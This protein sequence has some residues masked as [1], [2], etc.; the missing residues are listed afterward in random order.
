MKACS[1]HQQQKQRAYSHKRSPAVELKI[2]DFKPILNNPKRETTKKKSVIILETTKIPKIASDD[3]TEEEVF[4]AHKHLSSSGSDGM[5][6]SSPVNKQKGGAN[7]SF[8]IDYMSVPQEYTPTK[9]AHQ[10][11]VVEVQQKMSLQ[12]ILKATE[13]MAKS[14]DGKKRRTR[15]V[16]SGETGGSSIYER[17]SRQWSEKRARYKEPY[18]RSMDDLANCT[19]KPQINPPSKTKHLPKSYSE[20]KIKKFNED[21]IKTLLQIPLV[22]TVKRHN[23][24]SFL[25]KQNEFV[26]AKEQTARSLAK[27]L[28][29]FT[30]KPIINQYSPE[31]REVNHRL[32]SKEQQQ[33]ERKRH[34]SQE[35]IGY[36]KQKLAKQTALESVSLNQNTFLD[37]LVDLGF[38]PFHSSKSKI[39]LKI[40]DR[41][42][43]GQPIIARERMQELL[44]DLNLGFVSKLITRKQRQF[45]VQNKLSSGSRLS[46]TKHHRYSNHPSPRKSQS[47]PKQKSI[48]PSI[49]HPLPSSIS[50]IL[51]NTTLNSHRPLMPN[52]PKHVSFLESTTLESVA[53]RPTIGAPQLILD[54]NI[55]KTRCQRLVIR[56]GDHWPAVLERFCMDNEIEGKS[57]KRAK[58]WEEVAKVF[59]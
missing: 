33:S 20:C 14:Q 23:F 12:E 4:S 44:L 50:D 51:T 2:K 26:A 46:T 42:S 5:Y 7:D 13:Q 34:L 8:D 30:F 9:L 55:S 24:K 45:L 47:P 59:Q 28:N 38:C 18:F 21:Y 41:V 32:N 40:W 43:Q 57:K 58:L 52:N 6:C 37:N 48:T 11:K 31:K 16:N 29:N 36:L 49:S 17:S 10:E 54:V 19:F 39:M 25:E 1:L 3:D 53:D 22:K 56:Q 27:K 15:N 35:S